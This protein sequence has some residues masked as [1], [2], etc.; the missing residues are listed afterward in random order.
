M[1]APA[2]VMQLSSYSPM[3]DIAFAV[4]RESQRDFQNRADAGAEAAQ[5]AVTGNPPKDSGGFKI[6]S[7]PR[8]V[9]LHSYHRTSPL[10]FLK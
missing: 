6:D 2:V 4:D 5:L 9:M 7:Q 8:V 3:P 1:D 10:V